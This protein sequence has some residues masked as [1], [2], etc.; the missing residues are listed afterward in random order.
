MT[1][2]YQNN[3]SYYHQELQPPPPYSDLDGGSHAQLQDQHDENR[4]IQQRTEWVRKSPR[5]RTVP[6]TTR[7]EVWALRNEAVII[8]CVPRW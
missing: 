4:F 6:R 3:M 5:M 8:F 1:F 7:L 2:S